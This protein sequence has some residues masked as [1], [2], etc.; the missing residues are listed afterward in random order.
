MSVHCEE[1]CEEVIL[2]RKTCYKVGT[3]DEFGKYIDEPVIISCP[4]DFR[5]KG[6]FV[7]AIPHDNDSRVIA[8]QYR[9]LNHHH[10]NDS[11]NTRR[12]IAKGLRLYNCFK[13]AHHISDDYLTADN[14]DMLIAFLCGYDYNPTYSHMLTSRSQAVVDNILSSIRTYLS[15][16]GKPCAYLE[17]ARVVSIITEYDGLRSTIQR[18]KYLTSQA[19][20]PHKDD[21]AP[22]HILP[23]EYRR[24]REIASKRG[25]NQAIIM[26]V[27]MYI[28][29]L[30]LGECLGLTQED[31]VFVQVN[32]EL[33]P[34]LI[35]RKRICE[36]TWACAKNLKAVE[37]RSDYGKKKDKRVIIFITM[38]FYQDLAR[39]VNDELNMVKNKFTAGLSPLEA[40]ICNPG[41]FE[42]EQNHYLFVNHQRGSRLDNQAWGR[43]LKSLLIEAGIPL[44]AGTR[45]KNLSHRFRHGCA[46]LLYRYLE[47]EH[48]KSLREVQ[49]YLRHANIK[50]TMIYTKPTLADTSA[51]KESFQGELFESSPYLKF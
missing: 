48:R 37:K 9:F 46:M 20:D 25:N 5:K 50:T 28:Y 13:A 39:F 12:A 10:R 2:R 44:D 15:Y 49:L 32:D 35:L 14:I 22:D 3:V 24:L 30:R 38:D 47:P 43:T 45:D 26:M 33:K 31:I 4:L 27:L 40:D 51:I 18:T 6:D 29:G 1:F 19:K 42:H 11:E 41:E 34:A 23:E 17:Q 16:I 7:Y 36:K 21:Y 8:D